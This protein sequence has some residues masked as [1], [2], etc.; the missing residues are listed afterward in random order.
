MSPEV[1]Q[2]DAAVSDAH[3]TAK[4]KPRRSTIMPYPPPL[5]ARVPLDPDLG[6][7]DLREPGVPWRSRS[8]FGGDA[9]PVA[10]LDGPVVPNVKKG[11]LMERPPL[12]PFTAETA[13]QKARMPED[14]WNSRDPARVALACSAEIR[15]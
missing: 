9:E 5:H 3:A 14:A 1:P 6:E 12:P 4:P 11:A 7:G 13:G 10:L 2:P 8:L 15:R